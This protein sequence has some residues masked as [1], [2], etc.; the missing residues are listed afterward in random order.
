M[1]CDAMHSQVEAKAEASS[2]VHVAPG[3]MKPSSPMKQEPAMSEPVKQE[4]RAIYT[5]DLNAKPPVGQKF[6]DGKVLATRDVKQPALGAQG[7]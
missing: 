6:A 1:C 5:M 4:T 7:V 2:S 3:A